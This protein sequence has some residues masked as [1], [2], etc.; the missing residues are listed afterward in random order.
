M[1]AAF[2]ANAAKLPQNIATTFALPYGVKIFPVD[3]AKFGPEWVITVENEQGQGRFY[4]KED[5]HHILNNASAQKGAQL[6]VTPTNDGAAKGWKV[7]IDGVDF[8]MATGGAPA[9]AAQA[10]AG[11]PAQPQGNTARPQAQA[12]QAQPQASQADQFTSMVGVMNQC[13]QQATG[14]MDGWSQPE[15]QAIATTLFIESMR[16]GFTYE[17]ITQPPPAPQQPAQQPATPGDEDLPF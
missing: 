6:S 9:P 7:E 13:I 16:K 15:V 14:I 3:N 10:P 17:G 8:S 4:F 1:P 5:L 11:A 12:Q 2:H